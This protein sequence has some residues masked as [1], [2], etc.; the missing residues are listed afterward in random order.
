MINREFRQATVVTYG[1]ID[2]YGQMLTTPTASR[3]ISVTLNLYSHT[4]TSD[5]RFQEVSHVALTKDRT[6]TDKDVLIIDGKEFKVFF[7]NPFGR[8]AQVFLIG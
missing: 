1:G 3:N 5:V 6:I 7:V 4:Q 8:L 2:E